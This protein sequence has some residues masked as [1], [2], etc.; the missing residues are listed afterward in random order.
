MILVSI[1]HNFCD[2]LKAGAKNGSV[3]LKCIGTEA[4]TWRISYLWKTK[5]R[6]VNLKHEVKLWKITQLLCAIINFFV[7][8][9]GLSKFK[10][11]RHRKMLNTY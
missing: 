7:R 6:H 8:K 5:C 2:V 9:N 11:A 4:E 3:D 10:R 1:I